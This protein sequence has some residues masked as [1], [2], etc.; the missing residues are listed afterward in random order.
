MNLAKDCYGKELKIGDKVIPICNEA[1]TS[2]ISGEIQDIR[3]SDQDALIDVFN[4]KKNQ[5]YQNQNPHFFT[6]KHRFDD[7]V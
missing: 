5:L 2:D 6:T 3:F 7:Y 1:L 4:P